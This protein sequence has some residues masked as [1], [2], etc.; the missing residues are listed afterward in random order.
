M[1]NPIAGAWK[2]QSPN[3]ASA[4]GPA[5]HGG[6][7][8]PR[9][10]GSSRRRGLRLA[11]ALALL[12]VLTASLIWVSLWL[13]PAKGTSVVV[14]HAGYEEILAVPHNAGGQA[15]ALAL[16]QL[17]SGTPGTASAGGT[18]RLDVKPRPLQNVEEWAQDL[19]KI[20]A[21]TMILFFA[22]HGGADSKGA[23]LLPQGAVSADALS[24]GTPT[25]SVLRLEAVFERLKKTPPSQQILMVLDCDQLSASPPLGMLH[26]DFIHELQR[27]EDM[28]VEI[29]NLVV[30]TS[31]NIDQHSWVCEEV[32]KTIFAHFLIEGLKGAADGAAS[33]THERDGRI[34]A[35]ELYKYVASNVAEWTRRNRDAEQTPALWPQKNALGEKRARSIHLTVVPRDYV[36]PLPDVQPVFVAGPGLIQAWKRRDQLAAQV[37]PPAVYAPHL[38]RLH[39][40]MLMRYEALLQAGDARAAGGLATKLRDLDQAIEFAKKLEVAALGATLAMPALAYPWLPADKRTADALNQLWDSQAKDLGATWAL[41][42]KPVADKTAQELLRLKLMELALERFVENP[43]ANLEKTRQILLAMDNPLSARPAEAHFLLMMDRDLARPDGSKTG[44]PRLPPRYLQQAM[45]VRLRAERAALGL[46]DHYDVS[47]AGAYPFA[48]QTAPWVKDLVAEGDKL[49]LQGQDLLLATDESHWEQA[50]ELLTRADK[51]YRQAQAAGTRIQWA[52]SVRDTAL[53]VLPY[54]GE[55]LSRRAG[56]ETETPPAN[57]GAL[58]QQVL[59]LWPVIHAL[60]KLLDQR[61]QDG[62]SGAEKSTKRTQALQAISD[63][64]AAAQQTLGALKQAFAEYCKNLDAIEDPLAAWLAVDQA[65][66]CLPENAESRIRL[67]EKRSRLSR[68]LFDA[69]QQP[70]PVGKAL[71]GAKDASTQSK[72]EAQWRGRMLVAGMGK[73]WI[74]GGARGESYDQL[75][76]RL[77]RLPIEP[78]WR[79]SLATVAAQLQARW[80]ALPAAIHETAKKNTPANLAAGDAAARLLD[81]PGSEMIRD[82]NPCR[83]HRQ[84]LVQDLL[85]WQAERTAAEHW[86]ALDQAGEPYFRLAGREYLKGARGHE[87]F[88]KVENLLASDRKVA[89]SLV[90]APGYR[91]AG[92]AVPVLHWTSEEEFPL[93]FRLQ[94][95]DATDNGFPVAWIEATDGVSLAGIGQDQ[96]SVPGDDGGA[97]G[98]LLCTLRSRLIRNAEGAAPPALPTSQES[99]VIVHAL[100]RGERI[101]FETRVLIHPVAQVVQTT[102][103]VP[104]SASVAV[105][106][107]KEAHA[108]LGASLGS[109]VI[110]LDCS[111]SMGARKG[112]PVESSKWFEATEALGQ[113]LRNVPRGA[114]VS[115]WTFGQAVGAEKTAANPA[116]T[117]EALSPP[118]PWNPDD[119]EKID[120]LVALA[121]G[122]EPWNLSPVLRAMYI[123]AK[124]DLSTASGFKTMVVITDGMDNCFEKDAA[125]SGGKK[126]P[127]DFL[128]KNFGDI[129]INILGFRLPAGEEEQVRQQFAAIAELPH[130]GM[131]WPVTES[132]E[133]VFRIQK[134]LPQKLRYTLTN[135][136]G[137][138]VGSAAG[139]A[140]EVSQNGRNDQWVAG[141]LEAGSYNLRLQGTKD[142]SRMVALNRG[143]LLLLELATNGAGQPALRRVVYSES[144]FPGAIG[145]D[146][147]GWRFA[148]LQ[149]Q[150]V[151]E[152][153]LQ[154]L[155]TLEKEQPPEVGALQMIKPSKVWLE[156]APASGNA[157]FV[158]RWSNQPGYPAPA[159]GLD[160]PVWPT[161]AGG[162]GPARPVARAWWLEDRLPPPTAT[163]DRGLDFRDL[164]GLTNRAIRVDE[165]DALLE[166]VCVEEHLVETQPGAR[167]APGQLRQ[168]P[169]LVV[170]VAHAPNCP[171]WAQIRG[172]EAAGQEHR[173]YS[174]ANKY[175]AIFW[176][177]SADQA[178]TLL[179]GLDIFSVNAFKRAAEARKTNL[180]LKNLYEPLSTDSRPPQPLG[181]AAPP[182]VEQE[183]MLRAPGLPMD[184]LPPLSKE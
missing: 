130:K 179:G 9:G 73:D 105:R 184:V 47:L 142:L 114:R 16:A 162:K 107:P 153:G 131:F 165:R 104:L 42:Q 111:G 57:E 7:E 74:E 10:T 109:V 79:L 98:A 12:L 159:W 85:L 90:K 112:Q 99:K 102:H 38:W 23:F 41:L 157:A 19:H 27:L 82:K 75:Q 178:A 154:M 170:R 53:A 158:S 173:Y 13:Q 175:T 59:E 84:R 94:P 4:S 83:G 21:R 119:A 63:V 72:V 68:A 108:D 148:V 11:A 92:P 141:G 1:T 76:T 113:V 110:V 48:E 2:L 97:G 45:E 51:T 168:M 169:C 46:R 44:P 122:L 29:P 60:G 39:A 33:G 124:K 167:G 17:A 56:I 93:Q 160:I 163:F 36:A 166:S 50:R 172:L 101:D 62:Y 144:D 146:R 136:G 181:S 115:I 77:E 88:K 118:M 149:N 135:M 66:H 128:L 137:L 100:Y 134:I 14:I 116:D 95:G 3:P 89:I 18:L 6:G 180:E 22:V 164:E 161:Q 140:L 147:E 43:S 126:D 55:W 54:Y 78:Q 15:G 133:L 65:L 174:D 143:D 26:N 132:R 177:V 34:N 150:R 87:Q 127:R 151:D 40:S 91:A 121:K 49:R 182:Q 20:R 31:T 129:Q 156:V 61:M 176:P 125:L 183:P 64:T 8:P 30:L 80:F 139:E 28:I 123:A 52:L 35:F 37:P 71:V 96:R 106:A 138:A 67:L 5:W 81:G 25:S 120:G 103:P 155:M 24:N 117:I 86:A 70:H 171:V 58:R 152:R 32:G 69:S 145:R